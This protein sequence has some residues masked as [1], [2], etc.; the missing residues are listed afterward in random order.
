MIR[1]WAEQARTQLLEAHP[2]APCEA[3]HHT[4]WAEITDG[5]TVRVTRCPCWA[6]H[7]EQV[8][9]LGLGPA[10]DEAATYLGSALSVSQD[11]LSSVGHDG[12]H[13]PS[14]RGDGNGDVEQAVR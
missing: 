4:G 3:C 12:S 1:E 6:A 2:Y 14:C 9:R 5:T 7:Q 8:V 13:H 10:R 11:R